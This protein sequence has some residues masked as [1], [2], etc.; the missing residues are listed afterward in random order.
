ES[1][2][3]VSQ[4]APD[5]LEVLT[6]PQSLGERGPIIRAIVLGADEPDGAVCVYLTDAARSGG[7]G[8]SAADDQELIVD[9][10]HPRLS[11][12]TLFRAVG[13]SAVPLTKEGISLLYYGPR[14]L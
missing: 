3:A 9:H 7:G 5:A 13:C 10:G 1:R 4:L 6:L 11:A 14:K 8:H 12:C 2:G